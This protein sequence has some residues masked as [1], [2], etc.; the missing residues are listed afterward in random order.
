MLNLQTEIELQ[1]THAPD[2]KHKPAVQESPDQIPTGIYAIGHSFPVLWE[3]RPQQRAAA[4]PSETTCCQ[5]MPWSFLSEAKEKA[6]LL[7]GESPT[8]RK[9][10]H[11]A[12]E[13]GWRAGGVPRAVYLTLPG[14]CALSQRKHSFDITCSL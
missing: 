8:Q 11:H 7:P 14:S 5:G 9:K 6:N 3:H 10:G 12:M 13:A 4:S 1:T 2:G